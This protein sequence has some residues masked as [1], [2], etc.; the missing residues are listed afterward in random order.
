[1]RVRVVSLS[2]VIVTILAALV[3]VSGGAQPLPRR[4]SSTNYEVSGEA[5]VCSLITA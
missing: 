3:P 1:M 4:L 5:L 2:L